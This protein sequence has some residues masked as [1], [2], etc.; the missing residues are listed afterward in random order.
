MT[1]GFGT[2]EDLLRRSD[3]PPG[4]S[5]RLFGDAPERGMANFSGP[6]Q[7]RAGAAEI[8]TGEVFNLDYP[9]DAF[10]PSVSRNRKPPSQT[11]TSAH[12][13]SFDDFWDGYWPQVS[14]HL[15]GLRH[16]RAHGHGF[17]NGVADERIRAGTPDL[18]VQRWAERPIAGRAVLI[19]V[20]GHRRR[21]GSPIDHAAGEPITTACLADALAAQESTVDPGDIVLLHTG[22]AEWFLGLSP[23]ER[24]AARSRRRTTGV[25]QEPEFL[26]WLW[27]HRVALLGTDTFAV[28]ALPAAPD[29]PYRAT[30]GADQGMLHQELIAKLGCPLGELWKL[31]TLAAE[32]D[33]TGRHAFFASAK[34]L[35]LPGAVGSPAN[36]MAIL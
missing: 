1:A 2:Y 7:V 6:A 21:T 16:R 14:S 24:E 31:G 29:S 10:V 26:A 27:D 12:P 32:C 19:D 4:S 20:A 11:M 35:N 17:Y 3:A 22:W 9:A 23:G 13:D 34:P 5:W 30:S 36:A 8:R 33:R 15:D 25:A 18:G 28:E